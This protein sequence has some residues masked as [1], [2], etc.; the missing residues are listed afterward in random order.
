MVVANLDHEPRLQWHPFARTLR[1]PAARS[2]RCVAAKAWR[3]NQGFELFGK[4]RL[5]LL[6]D[7][8]GE[9]DVV[10]QAA[11][12]VEAKQQRAD[13]VCALVVAEAADHAVGAAVVLDLLHAGAIARAIIE[14]ALLGDHAVKRGAGAAQPFLRFGEFCSR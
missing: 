9:A 6:L 12:I 14:V 10:E 8:R 11:A 1:R 7:R 5:V 4:S 13:D 3:S 2:P